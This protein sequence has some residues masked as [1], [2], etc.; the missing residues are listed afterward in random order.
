MV[1]QQDNVRDA[2]D[3]ALSHWDVL[4]FA[5]VAAGD[6]LRRHAGTDA[7]SGT[8]LAVLDNP[9][10]PVTAA[11]NLAIQAAQ[12]DKPIRTWCTPTHDGRKIARAVA[13]SAKLSGPMLK[14]R[15]EECCRPATE[16]RKPSLPLACWRGLARYASC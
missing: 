9:G 6:A 10:A 1:D 3:N 15:R 11:Y 16:H 7:M 14:R 5:D 2:I 12:A 4:L 8:L 13:R